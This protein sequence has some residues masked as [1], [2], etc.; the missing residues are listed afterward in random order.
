LAVFKERIHPRGK[1]FARRD[2]LRRRSKSWHAGGLRRLQDIDG[3]RIGGLAEAVK[4]LRGITVAPQQHV[5]FARREREAFLVEGA[6]TLREA[7]AGA[8]QRLIIV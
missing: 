8:E 7:S 4:I 2:T 3:L 5:G 1:T 6:K